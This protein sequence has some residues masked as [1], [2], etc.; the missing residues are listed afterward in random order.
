MVFKAQGST[1]HVGRGPVIE[2]AGRSG[3]IKGQDQGGNQGF[4]AG[5]EGVVSTLSDWFPKSLFVFQR[6]SNRSNHFHL[7]YTRRNLV[8]SGTAQFQILTIKT[9][10]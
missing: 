6:N 9:A 2:R 10:R 4:D 5:G 3:V 7:S 8:Q 1:G